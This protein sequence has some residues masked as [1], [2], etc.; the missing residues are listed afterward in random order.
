MRLAALVR[1]SVL[2]QASPVTRADPRIVPAYRGVEQF[3]WEQLSRPD[4]PAAST[5]ARLVIEPYAAE[6][7]ASTGPF[8]LLGPGASPFEAITVA[9]QIEAAG[10]VSLASAALKTAVVALPSTGPLTVRLYAGALDGALFHLGG[11]GGVALGSG[12]IKLF[13]YPT[14]NGFARVRYS[15]AHEYHHEALRRLVSSA[16]S[17]GTLDAMI[18]EG[19][20]DYF[21]TTLHPAL[22]PKHTLAL[23]DEELLRVWRA[24][25]QMRHDDVPSFRSR[26]MIAAQSDLPLWAGYRL[27]YEIVEACVGEQQ[28]RPASGWLGV[29]PR[30]CLERFRTGRRGR[31]L[32]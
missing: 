20:A 29:D 17:S 23:S 7:G 2:A 11:T 13:L 9:Q 32:R 25:E 31:S 22:R 4:T 30:T 14:V 19:K 10:V 15:V 28:R 26:F 27:G 8:Q 21:A 6:C 24:F 3:G 5:Y 18:A 1:L 12:R 16:F